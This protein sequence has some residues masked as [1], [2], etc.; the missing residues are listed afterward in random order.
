MNQYIIEV[1]LDQGI[2]YPD[3]NQLKFA[4][5]AALAHFEIKGKASVTILLTSDDRLRALN[6]QFLG[7]D[8][9]T[10]VLSF[11]AG[12]PMPGAE[13]NNY[14]GDI[15]ISMPAVKRQA[16]AVGH[17]MDDELKLLVIHAILHLMGY[18][19]AN[20]DEKKEMFDLQDQILAIIGVNIE[21]DAASQ[22]VN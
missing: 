18:D 19:H 21:A 14:L 20:A 10:D 15:A 22:N 9:C 7:Y 17:H 4:A 6:R 13:K 3:I 2:W 11:P 1:E 8:E 5:E 12:E 16:A